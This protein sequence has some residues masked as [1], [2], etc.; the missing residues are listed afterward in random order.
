ME[1]NN[2]VLLNHRK[3]NKQMETAHE[4]AQILELPDKN[5]EATVF[6]MLKT[7]KQT[8]MMSHQTEYQ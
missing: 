3:K 2:K 6:N 1:I 7:W 5:F 8:R 4:E